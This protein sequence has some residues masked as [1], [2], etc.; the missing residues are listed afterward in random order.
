MT[1]ASHTK[2]VRSGALIDQCL[3]ALEECMRTARQQEHAPEQ[4]ELWERLFG[5]K[6]TVVSVLSKL[7]SMQK[8]LQELQ[9]NEDVH[10]DVAT[11][12]PMSEQDWELLELCVQRWREREGK[13]D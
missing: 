11:T 8:T 6:E 10:A 1:E 3:L 5:Q 13:D 9:E 12:G 4:T 7:V 2:L